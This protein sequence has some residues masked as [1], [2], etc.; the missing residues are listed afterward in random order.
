[1][2]RKTKEEKEAAKREIE[3]ANLRWRARIGQQSDIDAEWA[4]EGHVPIPRKV[5][6]ATCG[7][8]PFD[9]FELKRI[10]GQLRCREHRRDPLPTIAAAPTSSPAPAREATPPSA[11]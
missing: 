2:T 7:G 11:A 4:A 9:G 3:E 10:N 1:M 8:S 6:C 5:V